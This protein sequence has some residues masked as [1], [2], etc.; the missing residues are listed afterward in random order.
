MEGLEKLDELRT[1]RTCCPGGIVYLGKVGKHNLGFETQPVAGGSDGVLVAVHRHPIED[2]SG[3]WGCPGL[4]GCRSSHQTFRG[5]FT[6]EHA[7]GGP[8]QKRIVRFAHSEVDHNPFKTAFG[9]LDHL[10]DEGGGEGTGSPD[11]RAGQEG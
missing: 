7:R 3:Q 9:R 5:C 2:Q 6:G 4:D 11:R 10:T 8:I 1:R